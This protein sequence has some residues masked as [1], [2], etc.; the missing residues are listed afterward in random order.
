MLTQ[1]PRLQLT[2]PQNF[3]N[4]QI[5]RAVVP[6]FAG[7]ACQ[8]ANLSNDHLM[9]VQ[10]PGKLYRDGLTSA[11]WRL[12][13]RHLSNIVRHRDADAAEELYPLGDGVDEFHLLVEV[14]VEKQM[15]LVERRPGDLRCRVISDVRTGN[16]AGVL[17]ELWCPFSI[18]E[19]PDS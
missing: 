14:L 7:T 11:G 5:V 17:G 19:T 13:S 1:E 15:Q 12:D 10:Q 3:A 16:E 6:E 9:R 8:F 18:Q 2:A 4:N